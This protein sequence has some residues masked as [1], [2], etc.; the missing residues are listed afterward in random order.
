MDFE[1]VSEPEDD[2]VMEWEECFPIYSWEEDYQQ[3]SPQDDKGTLN[4]VEVPSSYLHSS[5]RI[6]GHEGLLP[7]TGAVKDLS[8]QEFVD[9]QTS[10]AHQHGYDTVWYDLPKPQG[11]SGV[12]GVDKICRQKAAVHCCLTDGTL[13]KYC[14]AVIPGSGVPPLVGVDTMSKLNVFFGTRQGTFTMVPDGQENDI[15][16]PEGTKHYQCV[17][18]P[19]G[20]WLLTVS[21]WISS[22][23]SKPKN[24]SAGKSSVP[25]EKFSTPA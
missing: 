18:A 21:A 5:T 23:Q 2:E 3:P 6:P 19:S 8:G 14:P 13:M 12:G 16:W 15:I 25:K 9:R 24:V 10:E 11:V 22:Q 17:K 1:D 20:H 7:D 4:P